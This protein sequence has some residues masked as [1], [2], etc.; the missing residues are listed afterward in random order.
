M[1]K[2]VTL[3]L[4][5]LLALWSCSKENS[6]LQDEVVREI[7]VAVPAETKAGGYGGDAAHVT[8]FVLEAY[9]VAGPDITGP[10]LH[11][12]MVQENLPEGSVST[13]FSLILR[14]STTYQL[15]IWADSGSGWYDASSLKAVRDLGSAAC[16]SDSADAF[17]AVDS[18]NI[19]AGRTPEVIT[20]KRPL[21]QIN[22]ITTDA[23][24]FAMESA[25]PAGEVTPVEVASSLKAVPTVYNVATGEI[26]GPQDVEIPFTPLYEP[27]PGSDGRQILLRKLLFGSSERG[28]LDIESVS[29][30]AGNGKVLNLP[31][32]TNIPEQSNWRTNIAG[33]F[34]YSSSDFSI[35]IDP[36]WT[37]EI[38]E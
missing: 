21:A 34:L 11:R 28:A 22:L 35:V 27:Y 19:L 20:L 1:T 6:G 16:N 24:R 12:R 31:A 8:R 14:P 32:I 37:G 2:R 10:E 9:A 29:L 25:L 3:L 17:C 15:L 38:Q 13:S 30:K 5:S 33:S 23:G 7:R 36:L 26:S 4:L 18:C